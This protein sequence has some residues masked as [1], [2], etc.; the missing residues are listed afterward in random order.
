MCSL[1]S[2]PYISNGNRLSIPRS[3]HAAAR[4]GLG[5]PE[6]QES[7]IVTPPYLRSRCERPFDVNEG[8]EKPARQVDE[9]NA[10]IQQ[11]AAA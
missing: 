11:F 3:P 7:A 6:Q 2:R 5:G 10:L 9:V 1:A 4:P 8:A